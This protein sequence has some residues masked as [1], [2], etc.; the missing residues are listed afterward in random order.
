MLGADSMALNSIETGGTEVMR[1]HIA[2]SWIVL[3]VCLIS[4]PELALS[5][6]SLTWSQRDTVGPA[7]GWSFVAGDFNQDYRDDLVGYYSGDGSLWTAVNRGGRFSW[8]R[9]DSKVSPA[10][11]WSFVAGNFYTYPRVD[12]VGYYSGDGSLWIAVNTSSH[13]GGSFSPWQQWGTVQPAAGWSF[14]AGRFGPSYYHDLMGY[15]PSNGSVWITTRP[16]HSPLQRDLPNTVLQ[17]AA[18]WSFM[19]NRSNLLNYQQGG[20]KVWGYHP[21]N[22]SLWEV[23]GYCSR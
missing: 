2:L 11:G 13:I 23:T 15:H 22:G 12:L 17:P 18:D 16:G 21:I 20:W 1:R 7:A 6:C 10:A 3:A 9:W 5:N 14:V 8:R 4:G 19:S